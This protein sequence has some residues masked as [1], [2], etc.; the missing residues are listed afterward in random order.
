MDGKP[1]SK[2][3][4]PLKKNRSILHKLLAVMLSVFLLAG[5]IPLIELP[6]ASADTWGG[7][8]TT[9]SGYSISGTTIS[10]TTANGFAYIAD[11]YC[12]RAES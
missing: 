8:Y 4:I 2:G 12:S 10:I 5:F 1:F 7:S 3:G 11:R 6:T 9:N